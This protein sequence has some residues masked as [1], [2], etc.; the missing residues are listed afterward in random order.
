MVSMLWKHIT[1]LLTYHRLIIYEKGVKINTS[2][3]GKKEGKEENQVVPYEEIDRVKLKEIREQ[4]GKKEIPMKYLFIWLKGEEK[5]EFN[6]IEIKKI[7]KVKQMIE[8][9]I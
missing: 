6:F 7:K 9:R 4:S 1:H 2:P 5:L 3:K 8:D